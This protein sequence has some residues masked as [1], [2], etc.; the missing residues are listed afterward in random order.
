MSNR[1][2]AAE[3]VKEN[4]AGGEASAVATARAPN[5]LRDIIRE[6]L[7]SDKFGG[8]VQTRFP[9]EP[10]GYLHIGHAKA[11]CLDFGLADEFGGHTNLRFDD[12]NPEKEETEYV[13]SIQE[14][15]R[16]L[17]FEWDGLYYAS[18]YFDQLYEWALQL[19]R[20][21]KAYV[22]DLTAEQVREYRGTLTEPGKESPFRS[23]SVEE[24][25]DLFQRMRAGEFPDGSRT[26]RAKIEMASPNLN[27]RDPVMYRILH[28]EHHRTGNKWCIYPMYDYAHGQSDSIERV[29][30]SM[31][32][33][34]FADHRP[35]Y[36][37][38]IRELGI[39]PSQQIEFDRLG[40]TYT[41]LSKRKL[42]QL[43]RDGHVSGWNDP[44]MPTLS[45]IRRRGYTPEAIRNFVTAAGV[46]RTNGNT[47]LE[48]LEHFVREDLNRHAPR[49]M[50]VLRPL[51]VVLDNYP[52]GQVEEME[53]INNPEDASAGTRKVPFA[54]VLYIEQ[55]D[56][57][58]QPPKGYY[59]LSPGREVRLRYGYFVTCTNVVK[60]PRTGEVVEVHCT[61]DPATRGGNAPDGRKVKATIHWVSAAHALEAEVRLYDKLFTKPNPNE[62][63]EGQDFTTN[64]NPNSLEVLRG[65][66]LEP[67]LAGAAVGSRYQFERLGYFCVDPDSVPGRLVFNRTVALKDTWAKVAQRGKG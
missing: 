27:M 6:D 7:K 39:F 33:L 36:E 25:L 49:V 15:V 51:K 59:R 17:G 54:R 32:T 66:Q 12:T 43:V 31:C 50:A 20:A 34:E 61:Y 63:E 35:L 11:I 56:F 2:P 44:R 57:R 58:E 24:N 64:L 65:C 52:E 38:F 29:T 18:D 22:D 4:A 19:I 14:D 67:S 60:D 53:A 26:L 30:H 45:G 40:V 46:S 41:I 13:E 23:R 21:G 9:P 10:N 55:E 37:W 47:E 5:F 28:A 42:L 62:V 8:R 3:A 48:M 16:W 1:N